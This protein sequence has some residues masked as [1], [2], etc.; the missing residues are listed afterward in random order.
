[1]PSPEIVA[2]GKLATLIPLQR[3]T[4]TEVVVAFFCPD[5]KEVPGLFEAPL[6]YMR[7]QEFL[8]TQDIKTRVSWKLLAPLT[9]N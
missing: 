4:R 1:M 3:E 6:E 7:A 2:A 8:W 9:A 5:W